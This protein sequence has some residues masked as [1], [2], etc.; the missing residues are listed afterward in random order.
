MQQNIDGILDTAEQQEASD[1][2]LQEAFPDLLVRIAPGI[3]VDT[4]EKGAV[5]RLKN[6]L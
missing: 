4:R 3:Y 6:F 2:F 1:V 5:L